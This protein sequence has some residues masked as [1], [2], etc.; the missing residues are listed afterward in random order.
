MIEFLL[1][2]EQFECVIKIFHASVALKSYGNEKRFF[3]PPPCIYLIGQGWKVYRTRK[4]TSQKELMDNDPAMH[5]QSTELVAYIGIGSDHT[6]RQQLDF[7]KVRHPENSR[8]DPS[9]YDYCAAKNL[10]ISDSRKYFDLNVQFFN[11]YGMEIGSFVSRHIKVLSKP[12]Q[13]KQSI[14]NTDSKYQCIASGTKVAFFNRPRSQTVRTRYLH[15]EEN[16]SSTP[17][18]LKFHASSTKW[19]AFTI[20][21]FDDEHGLQET[22]K[23]TVRDGFVCYGSLVKIVD[24][25]TGTALPLLRIRKVDKQQV[26]LDASCSEEVSQLHRCALQMIDNE[27]V[28]LC[29][30][31]DEIVQ[32]QAQIID[33]NRHQIK[34]G[35]AWTII[36]ADKA[37]YRFF[38]AMGQVGTPISPC[39]VVGSLEVDGHGEAACVELHGRDFKPNLMIWFGSTPL[40]TIF[41]SEE[42]LSCEVPPVTQVINEQ[43]IYMFTNEMTGDIE[44]PISLVREDGVIYS[45]GLTFAYKSMERHGTVRTASGS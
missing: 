4:S 34:D 29:L 1:N 27:M 33:E 42:C 9:I 43:T 10:Y 5:Q 40:D 30:S 39:P 31:R 24:S 32:H 45:S 44:V 13:K 38:E 3:C 20:H 18:Q 25:V 28:Y 23:L 35:A 26:I 21:L 37:E 6:E 16:S 7:W 22:E 11:G 8:Q 36:S 2:K 14:K 41:R 12:S 17:H 19:G 15:V